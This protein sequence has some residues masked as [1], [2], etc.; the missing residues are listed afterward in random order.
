ML[1][2]FLSFFA[3]FLALIFWSLFYWPIREI[4]GF[5]M[6]TFLNG[7]NQFCWGSSVIGL[8]FSEF[9]KRPIKIMRRFQKVLQM[10]PNPSRKTNEGASNICSSQTILSLKAS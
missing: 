1:Q 6:I 4:G 9:N 3:G 5:M 7:I 2:S 8:E 10:S